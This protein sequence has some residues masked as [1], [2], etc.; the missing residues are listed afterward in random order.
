MHPRVL[1]DDSDVRCSS[2]N[3]CSHVSSEQMQE[4]MLSAGSRFNQFIVSKGAVPSKGI[5]LHS[6]RLQPVLL[7]GVMSCFHFLLGDHYKRFFFKSVPCAS[8]CLNVYL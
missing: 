4:V 2:S 5:D 3:R 8:M 7:A 6:S 1:A